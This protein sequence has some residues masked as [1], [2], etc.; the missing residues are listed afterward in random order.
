MV[1][2]DVQEISRNKLEDGTFSE[3]RHSQRD[4]EPIPISEEIM[5]STYRDTNILEV[6]TAKISLE[7]DAWVLRG[8][9]FEPEGGDGSSLELHFT[10]PA[11]RS[12]MGSV[13]ITDGMVKKLPMELL[14]HNFNKLRENG[15]RVILERDDDVVTNVYGI[16]HTYIPFHEV[17]ASLR[18]N[19]ERFNQILVSDSKFAL[20]SQERGSEFLLGENDGHVVGW[21]FRGL[22]ARM[23]STIKASVGLFRM[24]C[25]NGT[26]IPFDATDFT[27]SRKKN[28][29]YHSGLE[30]F[31]EDVRGVDITNIAERLKAANEFL[32]GRT[33]TNGELL[34]TFKVSRKVAGE[35]FGDRVIG[36]SEQNRKE[37][38]KIS[39]TKTYKEEFRGTEEPRYGTSFDI[40][41]RITDYCKSL[42]VA[43]QL[44]LQ[45]YV[46]RQMADVN[47]NLN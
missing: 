12:F 19:N 42:S 37:A 28:G 26:I 33:P 18:D 3:T 39:R 9:E 11:F 36:W 16:G 45:E 38:L 8:K 41:N 10:T 17:L 4:N 15:S 14:Q 6:P 35:S 5:R 22:N 44:E 46:G 30:G 7:N 23:Q 47:P 25:S 1:T 13:G 20:L 2:A 21:M 34:D 43:D 32:T 31:I 24:I 27:F 29:D 40:L